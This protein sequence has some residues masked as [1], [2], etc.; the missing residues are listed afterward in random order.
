M[1][2][3]LGLPTT[4]HIRTYLGTPIF[5]T[6]QTASSYQYLVDNIRKRIKGWQARYLSIAARTTLIKASVTSVPIYAMQT[7]LLPQKICQ[8]IDKLSCHFLWG[9]TD[10]RRQCP[11]VKWETVTLPKK[12]GGLG[13]TSTQHRNQAILMNQAWRLYSNLS[14][15]WA[16]VL[17][18][19]YFPHATLF[20]SPRT[21][22][23]SHIWTTLSLGVELI[24]EGMR[25]VVGDGRTIRIWKDHW[26]PNGSLHDYI[27][28]PLL[29]QEDDRLVNS[30]WSN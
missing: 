13:I 8:H 9:D 10:L 29:P 27:E 5:S 23:G 22:K 6:R 25:W 20:T 26:L 24:L 28:G 3:I 12:A 30:L 18:A 21:S 15:L 11:T 17:K 4:N 14:S 19:K 16:R 2:R 7:V 1:A